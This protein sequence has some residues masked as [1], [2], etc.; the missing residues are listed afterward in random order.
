M[1]GAAARK[2]LL[3]EVLILGLERDISPGV[4]SEMRK[5]TPDKIRFRTTDGETGRRAT[6]KRGGTRGH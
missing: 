3:G 1:V 2:P 6:G 5:I 4:D